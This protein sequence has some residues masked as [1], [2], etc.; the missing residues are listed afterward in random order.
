MVR[1]AAKAVPVAASQSLTDGDAG[2]YPGCGYPVAHN[3]I[4]H[5]GR[6]DDG[7]TKLPRDSF[8]SLVHLFKEIST[9]SSLVVP[10]ATSSFLST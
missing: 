3:I 8:V 7:T 9:C 6:H 5:N 4:S 2:C 10:N 1:L